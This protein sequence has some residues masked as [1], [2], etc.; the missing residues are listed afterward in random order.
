MAKIAITRSNFFILS[1]ELAPFSMF[2][3]N[4]PAVYLIFQKSYAIIQ[5]KSEQERS[6]AT[7]VTRIITKG[8][9][10]NETVYYGISV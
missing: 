9:N 1:R 4:I 3:K 7:S 8:V 5:V 2:Y 10:R 6:K